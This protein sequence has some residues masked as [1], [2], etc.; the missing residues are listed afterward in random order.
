M[1][2]SLMWRGIVIAGCTALALFYS[3]PPEQRIK[4][5]LDLRGGMH[6]VLE[7]QSEDALRAETNKDMEEFRRQAGNEGLTNVAVSR[8]DDTTFEA[9]GI[10]ADKAETVEKIREEIFSSPP[11]ET[12]RWT[13]SRD[14]ERLVFRMTDGNR[15]QIRNQ[16]VDQALQTIR[17]RIDTLGVSEPQ[18]SRQPGT[19]RLIA[20]LPGV[21]DPEQVKEIL[22]KTAFL[23]FRLLDASSGGQSAPTPEA[24]ASLYGGLIPPTVEVL[25]EIVRDA[26][27]N[28][29]SKRYWALE[30]RQVI[31]GRDLRV[32]EA[33]VDEFQRPAV[34]FTLT[35]DGARIFGK[36]TGESIGRLLSI[37]LDGKVQSVATIQSRIADRGQIT[38]SFTAE[39]VM[40]LVT[41]L[42]SGALPA[43]ITILEE[44]TV[45]ASLGADSVQ[46]GIRAGVVATVLTVVAM[47]AVYLLT[48]FNAVAALLLNVIL[49]F[50]MLGG[51]GAVLTL[52]GIAG[53]V[54]TIGMAFDAN[55][56]VF[57]RIREELKA[58]RT[59]RS[60]IDAGFSKA[61]SSIVDSNITTLVAAL[62]LFQFGTGPVKGFAVTL[63]IGIFATM[64]AG[65]FFSRWL[66]D[67]I[68]SW[69]KTTTDN[70]MSIWGMRFP[71]TNFNFMKYRQF[72]VGVSFLVIAAGLVA[73]FVTKKL[74]FGIDFTGGTQ[75]TMKLSSQPSVDEIRG[76]LASAGMGDA[77]IQTIGD[78]GENE[79]LVRTPTVPGSE[80]GRAKEVL[81][82]LKAK[83]PDIEQRS[84]ENV[85]AQVGSELRQKGLWAVVASM[86][87]MLIYIWIRFEL[88]FGVGALMAVV[89]DVLITLGL[90]AFSGLEFNLTT[91]AAF[92]T[93]VGYSVNDTVV[94][95]DRVRENMHKMRRTPLLE[96][97]NLSLN[98][99]LSRTILTGG[100][101]LT[102]CLA[103]IFLGGEVL[104]G[105]AFILFVGVIVGTYSSIYIA[106]PFALLWER[107]FGAEAKAARAGD[108]AV[109]RKA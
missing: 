70:K 59:V 30:S 27:G 67:W 65:V 33:G 104:R 73:V 46:K 52:P 21:D 58:G 103:L 8:V 22:K 106:S 36:V 86:I 95:F 80:E 96:V 23:E 18:L 63:M 35:A 71:V 97:M 5:G 39:E 74:N 99:T 109:P 10:G 89:H 17:N 2:K 37:V 44:R 76:V 98:Q 62:F 94:V 49:V 3:I 85:G 42:K 50:G 45:G 90:Y 66:F 47:I 82:A 87:G 51:A 81:K 102:A 55:V 16:A 93:L 38:G 34:H 75:L 41:T 13:I 14:G 48:G 57:E 53:I 4:K 108:G 15:S 19:E 24:M 43:G 28:E 88:R 29:T 11:P 31:T 12:S 100:T 60:S 69:R 40:V 83:Y 92:L 25:P 68:A 72:W 84:S 61:L 78:P 7:V 6:L 54:L 9:T 101:T 79:I 56:L 107:Y 1:N 77:T 64:F 26:A 105:F 20:Q 91:I 32:A